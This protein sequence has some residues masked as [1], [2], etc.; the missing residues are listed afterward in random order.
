[1]GIETE[2]SAR[3]TDEEVTK[4]AHRAAHHWTAHHAELRFHALRTAQ[5][6]K[7]KQLDPVGNH[8]AAKIFKP[9]SRVSRARDKLQPALLRTSEVLGGRILLRHQ[10]SVHVKRA[11]IAAETRNAKYQWMSSY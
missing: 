7:G 6:P 5:L 9:P 11:G 3:P 1:M 10:Q 4:A 8:Q 2:Q